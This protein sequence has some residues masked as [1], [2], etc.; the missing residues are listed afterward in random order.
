M[1]DSTVEVERKD[2]CMDHTRVPSSRKGPAKKLT[3]A[4]SHKLRKGRSTFEI[5]N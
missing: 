3:V 5:L 1:H 2:A 4:I